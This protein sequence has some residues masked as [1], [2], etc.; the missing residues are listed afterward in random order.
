MHFGKTYL[1]IIGLF[2]AF[3]VVST[4]QLGKSRTTFSVLE[5]QQQTASVVE[6]RIGM[7]PDV[8][9]YP[10][11]MVEGHS[12]STLMAIPVD[13]AGWFGKAAPDIKSK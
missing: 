8:K 11:T 10:G 7:Q 2:A 12:A 13:T 4:L 9:L 6:E 5:K 1:T 3:L